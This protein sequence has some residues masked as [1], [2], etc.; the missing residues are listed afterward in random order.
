L[1]NQYRWVQWNHH[2]LV[3]DLVLSLGV[4]AFVA[5]FIAASALTLKG[6]HAVSGMILGIRALGICAIVLLHVVLAIGPLARI[7]PRFAPLLYNRRHL[8]VFTFLVALLHAALVTIYYAGGGEENPITVLFLQRSSPGAFSFTNFPFVLLG[9]VALLILFLMAATSHDFWLANLGSRLWKRLHMLVY[10]AYAL[11]VMHVA[12]GALQSEKSLLLPAL[13]GAGALGLTLLHLLAA[14]TGRTV[15]IDASPEWID[16][17]SVDDLIENRGHVV[18]LKGP[19]EQSVALFRYDGTV[20]AVSNVCKHQ[21]GPM[22]E[23]EIIAGCVTCP[24]HGYQYLPHNGQSPPPYTEKIP[25]YQVR[26]EGDRVMLNP[27][28]NAPGTPIPPATING[29]IKK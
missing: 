7:S 29:A 25:T 26:I 17:C 14:Q 12:L 9:F 3:Y 10:A 6:E 24:W 18:R 8:G 1:T 4:L 5:V 20:S 22:G 2:K 28:P 27:K 15:P 21:G 23:G 13:L 11:A 16:A 19:S